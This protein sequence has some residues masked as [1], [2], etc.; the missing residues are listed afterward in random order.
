MMPV[1][2]CHLNPRG[3]DPP[4]TEQQVYGKN[5]REAYERYL[6]FL[7]DF[8]PKQQPVSVY[9]LG[10]NGASATVFDDHCKP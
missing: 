3:D 6:S 1:Y 10:D 9:C 7:P 8:A 2:R 4:L 5:P